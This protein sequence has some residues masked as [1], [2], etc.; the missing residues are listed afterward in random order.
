MRDNELK[1]QTAVVDQGKTH[2]KGVFPLMLVLVVFLLAPL[3]SQ[4]SSTTGILP[5]GDG[6][7]LVIDG[8]NG[9]YKDTLPLYQVE[10]IP[11]FTAGVGQ[12]EREASY[13]PYSLKLEF[14]IKGGAFTGLV[15]VVL[16]RDPGSVELHIPKE[17]AK[18]PWLFVDAPPGVYSITGVRQEGTES[19]TSIK[20]VSGLVTT[21]QL[22]W[23]K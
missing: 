22:I 9:H 13:P 17:H 20:V 14:L 10:G 2:Q 23:D 8:A 15:D 7:E 11:Y 4:G 18:G 6:I 12:D 16:K 5:S 1:Y 19:K 21:V 3:P